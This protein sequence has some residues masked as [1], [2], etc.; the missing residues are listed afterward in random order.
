[1]KCTHVLL[2][3]IKQ[4]ISTDS[5]NNPIVINFKFILLSISEL[6]GHLG[7]FAKDVSSIYPLSGDIICA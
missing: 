1:M 2:L 7:L 6:F 3:Y 5:E 4:Q